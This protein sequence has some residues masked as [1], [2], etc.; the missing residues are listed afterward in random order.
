MWDIYEEIRRMEEM[1]DRLFREF[2]GGRSAGLLT[3]GRGS[4]V[5]Y[6][7][8]YRE[9]YAD[10][11]ETDKEVIVTAEIPGVNK[12]DININLTDNGI[13]ISA[14]TKQE[15]EKEEEGLHRSAKLYSKFYKFISLPSKIHLDKAKATYK[16]GVLEVKL[17]KTEESEKTTIKVE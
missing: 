5:P 7:D 15:A 6:S 8:R 12:S 11:Q 4:L 2:H 3:E 17:L 1:M 16:N 14:E 9:P 13:E 10:V